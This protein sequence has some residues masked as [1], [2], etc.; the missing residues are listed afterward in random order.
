ME[1]TNSKEAEVKEVKDL[2]KPSNNVK[3]PEKAVK[4]ETPAK[5]KA[6][7]ASKKNDW[8]HLLGSQSAQIDVVVKKALAKKKELVVGDLAKETKLSNG[9]VSLHLRHLR[10]DHKVIK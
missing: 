7:A 6:K 2:N 1:K 5:T 10:E 3:T 4:R 8:G 9:R